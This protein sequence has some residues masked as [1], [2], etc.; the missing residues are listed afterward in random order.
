MVQA[1]ARAGL[2]SDHWITN[3]RAAGARRLN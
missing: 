1:F 2:R 3:L